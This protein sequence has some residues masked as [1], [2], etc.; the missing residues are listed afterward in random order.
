MFA[1]RP[2]PGLMT[3]APHSRWQAAARHP[4]VQAAMA[5][6][7]AGTL[8][9]GSPLRVIADD[10]AVD[11]DVRYVSGLL[12]TVAWFMPNGNDWTNPYGPFRY[13]RRP[14]ESHSCRLRGGGHCGAG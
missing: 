9:M 7:D 2:Y 13:V 12:A 4:D 11:E 14:A 3:A 8:L 6:D 1:C 5:E 10:A